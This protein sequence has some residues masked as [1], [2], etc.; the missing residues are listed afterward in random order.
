MSNLAEM[1]ISSEKRKL[2]I[3][4]IPFNYLTKKKGFSRA[5]HKIVISLLATVTVLQSCLEITINDE[6]SNWFCTFN[7]GVTVTLRLR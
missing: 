7:N 1:F 6:P 2:Y 3:I 5:E 4:H